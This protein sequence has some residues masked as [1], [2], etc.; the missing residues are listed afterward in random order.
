M[1]QPIYC[2]IDGCNEVG[3]IMITNLDTGDVQAF[4]NPHY[5]EMIMNLAVSMIPPEDLQ[6]L[7]EG[8]AG[9]PKRQSR[10]KKSEKEPEPAAATTTGTDT[11]DSETEE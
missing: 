4:C 1:A 10:S 3:N 2:D 11:G 8:T 6:A 5:A 7:A 9:K